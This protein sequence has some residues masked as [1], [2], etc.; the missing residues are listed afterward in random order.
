MKQRLKKEWKN[1][2]TYDTISTPMKDKSSLRT[3]YLG[4]LKNQSAQDRL[5]KSEAIGQLL[6]DNP[7]Y[8]KAK[9]VLFYASLAH[10]VDTFG[11]I[12]KTLEDGK[13]V[14]LPIVEKTQRLIRPVLMNHLEE[15]QPSTY[16]ILEP[17]FDRKREINSKDLELVLVPGLAFDQSH[18]RLGRGAG[19]YDRF[20]AQLPEATPTLGL[21]FDFQLT[22]C[23]PTDSHDVSLTAVLAA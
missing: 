1:S 20:L 10:E 3:Y 6:R 8:R 22:Q 21:G 11:M 12:R 9:L 15:L 5:R 17:T 13:Q 14:C 23:L 4:L 18:N 19:Y 7:Y 2:K 16:G